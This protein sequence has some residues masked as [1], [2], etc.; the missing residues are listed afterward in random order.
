MSSKFVGVRRS[1]GGNWHSTACKTELGTFATEIEAARAHDYHVRFT[2]NTRAKLNFPN[3]HPE[4]PIKMIHYKRRQAILDE[5]YTSKRHVTHDNYAVEVQGNDVICGWVDLELFELIVLNEGTKA[6]ML[7]RRKGSTG[8]WKMIQNK[9]SS[10]AT[11]IPKFGNMQGYNGMMVLLVSLHC[12]TIIAVSGMYLDTVLNC[13]HTITVNINAPKYGEVITS[14]KDMTKFFMRALSD[15]E[16]YEWI[17]EDVARIPVTAT[18]QVE[19]RLHKKFLTY[20]GVTCPHTCTYPRIPCRSWDWAIDG[21]KRVQEMTGGVAQ[22]KS[23]VEVT[24]TKSCENIPYSSDDFHFL[25]VQCDAIESGFWLVPMSVLVENGIVSCEGQ[26]G[27]KG[28]TLYNPS[29]LRGRKLK[30]AWTVRYYHSFTERRCPFCI[31]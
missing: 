12:H 26:T 10:I 29:T 6:D 8:P 25:L 7:V 1:H 9:C 30:Y 11:T 23:G 18:R 31:E 3:E 14:S 17:S 13:G 28:C 2:K 20:L 4:K 21:D 19:W 24:F 16:E 27:R 5:S 22:G 15:D